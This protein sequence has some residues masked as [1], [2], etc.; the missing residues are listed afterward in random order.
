MTLLLL[1]SRDIT[2]PHE[3]LEESVQQAQKERNFVIL[4]I[5]ARVAEDWHPPELALKAYQ[6]LAEPGSRQEIAML[7]NAAVIANELKDTTAL[8]GFTGWLARLLPD[9]V[10][11]QHRAAYL[12]LLRG[13]MLEPP[14]APAPPQIKLTAPPD[15]SP[16]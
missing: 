10:L 8:A 4:S 11:I 1:H 7:E 9:N 6:T 16:P 2:K 5:D 12:R 14:S 13:E 15:C 3:L